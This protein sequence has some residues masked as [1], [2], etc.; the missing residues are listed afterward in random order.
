MFIQCI[1]NKDVAQKP[2]QVTSSEVLCIIATG[3][4]GSQNGPDNR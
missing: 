3:V 2:C 4:S 1:Q